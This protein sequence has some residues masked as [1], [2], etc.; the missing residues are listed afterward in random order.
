MHSEPRSSHRIDEDVPIS[1]Y[2]RSCP[3]SVFFIDLNFW[4]SSSYP[5]LHQG[6][7]AVR[8]GRWATDRG[9]EERRPHPAG[10]DLSRRRLS[11]GAAEQCS[12][13]G[14][15]VD[16]CREQRVPYPHRSP[17]LQDCCDYEP[18]RGL[19]QEGGTS[20]FSQSFINSSQSNKVKMSTIN[21][22][23]F[24]PLNDMYRCTCA[25]KLNARIKHHISS[26]DSTT[27]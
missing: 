2:T 13:S 17:K 20:I 4:L 26:R 9:N 16:S 10:R 11:A 12:G 23:V 5:F 15:T 3:W 14:E 27:S 6:R 1:Q 22:A 8:V 18:W 21:M 24:A 19:W 7:Q 25:R